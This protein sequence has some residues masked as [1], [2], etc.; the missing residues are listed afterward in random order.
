MKKLLFISFIL[1]ISAVFLTA[2]SSDHY[3]NIALQGNQQY[4]AGNYDSAL[5][6]YSSLVNANF[7]SANLYYNLGNTHYKLNEL[8][9]AIYYLEKA[10]KLA[11]FDKDIEFNL[12]MA[13]RQIVDRIEDVPQ[14]IIER[15]WFYLRSLMAIDSWAV[16]GTLTFA[17]FILLIGFYALS[18]KVYVKKLAFFTSLGFLFLAASSLI[19]GYSAMNYVKSEKQAVVFI[20]SLSVKAEP[21]S[22]SSDLFIVHEG[23]TVNVIEVVNNWARVSLP[24]G[25]EGWAPLEDIKRF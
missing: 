10:K 6:L 2:K 22:S 11:P 16:L 20:G 9:P 13:K 24:D 18:A 1:Q 12:N 23:T 19:F 7:S 14:P 21:N 3:Y 4:E 8:A 17:L 15:A 5:T 25:N